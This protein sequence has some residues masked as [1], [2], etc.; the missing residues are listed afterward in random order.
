M[1]HKSSIG[2]DTKL[3][4]GVRGFRTIAGLLQEAVNAK[5]PDAGLQDLL[6]RQL[7]EVGRQ[8]SEIEAW[9][10]LGGGF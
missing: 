7:D 5:P 9:Q 1:A 8:L 10:K 2:A 4:V 3:A 6:A